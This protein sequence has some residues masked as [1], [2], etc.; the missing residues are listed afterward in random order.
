MRSFVLALVVLLTSLSGWASEPLSFTAVVQVEG[1]SQAEL[2]VRAQAWFATTFKCGKCVMQTA[3]KEAGQV[4]GRGA[5][6][7][8]SATFLSSKAISGWVTYTVKVFVKDGRYKYEITDF[9]HEGSPTASQYGSYPPFSFG[10]VTTDENY[11]DIKY[12]TKGI[13]GKN[14][15]KLKKDSEAQAKSLIESLAKAMATPASGQNAW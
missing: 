8:A 13:C 10:L 14:W 15:E 2:F 11:P 6:E 1:V 12:C 3:D 4:I 9:M 5:Y 7:Y